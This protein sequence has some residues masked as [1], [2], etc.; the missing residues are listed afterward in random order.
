MYEFLIKQKIDVES[1]FILFPDSFRYLYGIIENNKLKGLDFRIQADL[2]TT[3]MNFTKQTGLDSSYIKS[4]ISFSNEN[5]N[6]FRFIKYYNII[7][8]ICKFRNIP[9]YWHSWSDNITEINDKIKNSYFKNYFSDDEK[10]ELN[11]L[12]KTDMARDNAHIAPK[13]SSKLAEIFY[14]KYTQKAIKIS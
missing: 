14:E 13:Y 2:N 11:K 4:Y 6:I 7:N 8:E 3:E 9:F 1:V 5:Y 10:I 12:K